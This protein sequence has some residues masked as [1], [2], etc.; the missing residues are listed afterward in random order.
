MR[1]AAVC[2][3]SISFLFVVGSAWAQTQPAGDQNPEG[4]TGALKAQ[5][6]TGGSYDAH[7]GNATRIVTDLRVPGALGAEGLVFMRYW[8]SLPNDNEN[9]YAVLP[10][11]FGPSNWSHSFEWYGNE[12]DTSEK[13]NPMDDNSEEI[14]TT[15]ITITFPDGHANR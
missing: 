14:W 12:E 7:S 9:P 6:T 13:I 3:L 11:S 5:I 8:N 15:A 2:S 4:N 10:A 1:K